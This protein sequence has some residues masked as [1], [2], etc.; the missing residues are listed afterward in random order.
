MFVTE[1]TDDIIIIVSGAGYGWVQVEGTVADAHAYGDDGSTTFDA[2]TF[3][4]LNLRTLQPDRWLIFL[5]GAP[6][7][8]IEA[9]DS[10]PGLVGQWSLPGRVSPGMHAIEIGCWRWRQEEPAPYMMMIISCALCVS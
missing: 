8:V 6:S 4:T 2:S 10:L 7:A 5:L 9:R 3:S 1:A